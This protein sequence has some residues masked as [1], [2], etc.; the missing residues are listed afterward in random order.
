MEVI[1]VNKVDAGDNKLAVT[2]SSARRKEVRSICQ[3]KMELDQKVKD[4]KT[5]MVKVKV[6]VKIRVQDLVR[7]R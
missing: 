4:R 2:L 7:D 5:D 1:P 3:R 6:R